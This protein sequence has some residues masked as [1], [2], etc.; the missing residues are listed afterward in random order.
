M[1]IP[2]DVLRVPR[3]GKQT[4]RF[5]F[6][7]GVAARGEHISWV[8]DP[9]MAGCA[10]GNLANVRGH[11]LLGRRRLCSSQLRPRRARSRAPTSTRS[12]ASGSDRNLFQQANGTFLPDESAHVRRR[13]Q[14]SADS[15]DP[16]RRHAQSRL[17]QRGDRSADDR[18]A[19]VPAA[20]RGVPAV[21]RARRRV[22]QRR[23][24]ARARRPER[25][26]SRPYLGLLLA[27]GRPVR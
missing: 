26:C 20:A 2:L 11:A 18:A 14:L 27:L 1:I 17:L 3:G 25:T 10:G 12:R 6:V 13:F 8:W 21:L 7:R 19:G 4:W 15:D 24:R 9:I 23:V 22:H 16:L 5:N